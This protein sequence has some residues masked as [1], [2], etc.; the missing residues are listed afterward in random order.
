MMRYRDCVEVFFVFDDLSNHWTDLHGTI[1]DG[2]L[3]ILG[4]SEKNHIGEFVIVAL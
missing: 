4:I 1:T 3:V 2:F